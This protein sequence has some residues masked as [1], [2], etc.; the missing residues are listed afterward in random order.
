MALLG[1]TLPGIDA[2]DVGK[3]TAAYKF[4]YR[5]LTT[6]PIIEGGDSSAA[7][8]EYDQEAFSATYTFSEW[9]VSFVEQTLA[10]LSNKEDDSSTPFQIV[11]GAT[12]NLFFMQLSEPIYSAAIK[13]LFSTVTVHLYEKSVTEVGQMCEAASHAQPTIALKL[14]IPFYY[15]TLV[16]VDAGKETLHSLSE[17]QLW[18]HLTLLSHIVEKSG[19]VLVQYEKQVTSILQVSLGS[20]EVVH[21]F[22][23]QNPC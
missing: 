7:Q 4:Y 10:F 5:V 15:K 19:S 3:T 9:A 17:D 20:E 16:S 22:L 8:S 2:N 1:L 14:F 13:K 6:V 12:I 18:W 11:Y 23:L 21:P